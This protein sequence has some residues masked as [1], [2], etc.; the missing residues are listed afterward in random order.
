MQKKH[1]PAPGTPGLP[2]ST[3]YSHFVVNVVAV[4]TDSGRGCWL[5]HQLAGGV[6][7]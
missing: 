1:L 6:G 3:C 5:L 2:H 7:V 4:T